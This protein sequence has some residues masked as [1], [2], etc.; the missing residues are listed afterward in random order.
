MFGDEAYQHRHTCSNT[1]FFGFLLSKALEKVLAKIL[2]LDR[3][4]LRKT[5]PVPT[6]GGDVQGARRASKGYDLFTLPTHLVSLRALHTS[7]T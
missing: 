5:T 1:F 3:L 6:S 4:V 7:S 2:E